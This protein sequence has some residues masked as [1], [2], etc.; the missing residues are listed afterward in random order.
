MLILHNHFTRI[1]NSHGDQVKSSALHQLNS[2]RCALA[3]K[4][5]FNWR[6]NALKL[7][8]HEIIF[9]AARNNDN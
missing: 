7:K 1:R 6:N 4:S 3:S 9:D 2:L 5:N 8:M